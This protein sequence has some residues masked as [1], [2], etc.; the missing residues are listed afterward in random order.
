MNDA[1]WAMWV[2]SSLLCVPLLLV[3]CADMT[4]DQQNALA[5]GLLGAGVHPENPD[6][7]A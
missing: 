6:Y 7:R 5:W 3:G 2:C 1:R 4:Q